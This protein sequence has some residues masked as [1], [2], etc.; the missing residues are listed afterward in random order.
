MH[1]A[2]YFILFGLLLVC[3]TNITIASEKSIIPEWLD[4]VPPK[5]AISPVSQH[6]NSLFYISFSSNKR[7]KIWFS[8]GTA[9]EMI[10]YSNPFVIDKDGIYKIYY[11]GEDDF[12]NKSE[13]DS[14]TYV[15]DSKSPV[16][17]V[18]PPPGIYPQK[19]SIKITADEPCLFSLQKKGMMDTV[20]FS[21]SI[22]V[23]DFF[24]GTITA[25]D[26]AGNIST[27]ANLKYSVDTSSF[28]IKIDPVGG[29]YKHCEL[30]KFTSSRDVSVFYS[31]DPLA[32]PD[33]FTRYDKPFL[34]PHGLSI[35]RFFGKRS[36]S[37][38]EIYKTRFIVDTI[39]PKLQLS[40]VSGNS[41]DTLYLSTREK[42]V[43][44]YTLDKTIPTEK[45]LPYTGKV[46]V[47]HKGLSTIKA[48]AWDDA[49]N[50]SQVVNWEY[51]YDRTPPKINI[52]NVSG[53]YTHPLRIIFNADEPVKIHYTLDGLPA[54]ENSLLYQQSGILITRNDTTILRY[55]GIDEA[56][57]K[58]EEKTVTYYLDTR[59]PEVK[60]SI[61]NNLKDSTFLINLKADEPAVI[62]YTTDGNDP[63]IKPSVY[64]ETIQLRFGQIL[65]YF[66]IDMAG[67]H[68]NIKT[69]DE[70]NR[71][72]VIADPDGGVF[73]SKIKI[74]F[75][76]NIEGNVY[77]RI[78]P[79]TAFQK[80]INYV[81][82]KNNGTYNFEYYIESENGMRSAVRRSVYYIDKTAP[83]VQVNLRKSDNDSIVVF[84]ESSE[85]ASIYYTLDGTNPLLSKNTKSIGNKYIL[86]HDRII[87][88]R[89]N[90][91]KLAF[92]AEDAAGNQ[93]AISVLDVFNPRA[94]P[95]VPSGEDR[96]YDRI[97]SITLNSYDKSTIYFERHGI[98]PTTTSPVYSEPLTLLSSDTITAF[99]IDASG[100]RG[101]LDTF[102]YLIDLPPSPQ[103]KISPDTIYKGSSVVFDPSGS[104]DK[105]SSFDKLLFRWDF[106]GDG[107]F[108]SQYAEYSKVSY[109]YEKSG[110]YWPVLEVVDENKRKAVIAK[111]ILIRE[112][113]SQEMI[114]VIDDG[115]HAFCIDRFEWP[116]IPD[117]K[118]LTNVSWV[119][120]K[121][122]CTDAG[123]R[124]CTKREWKAACNGEAKTIYPYGDRYN[125]SACPTEGKGVWKSGSFKTCNKYAVTDMLGNAWE[126]VERGNEDYRLM[127]GGSFLSGS[128]AHCGLYGEGTVATSSD[129]TGFRCCK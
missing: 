115:G 122:S 44:R 25:K 91:I 80:N 20:P 109:K 89:T 46:T 63:E 22:S 107:L 3:Y 27:T 60:V 59:L 33:Y 64:N 24:E 61:E 118:P 77:W 128:E 41:A 70:L 85:P 81:E 55:I 68:G 98:K 110:L 75:V 72:M 51:K 124:L 101:N 78:L 71:P 8:T 32:P 49:G 52:S 21:D 67:N 50:T 99:V 23:T 102:V 47:A 56:G 105:E 82:I 87:L 114:S 129:E 117:V 31:F 16:L 17:K 9:Y 73:N 120:A 2:I 94:V 45:S 100:H 123:K 5:I 92:F 42:S 4:T 26:R 1:K 57:N 83:F 112:R 54:T 13:I 69:M 93:S 108:D 10:Q 6:H 15:I 127:M 40:V 96:L 43:I 113:C 35:L 125:P 86:T 19:I 62:Y 65:K 38:S 18:T 106:D 76:K 7:C 104:L 97:L 84:F 119:E 79:D 88:R 74:N 11:Y 28:D 48:M 66:A 12:G 53:T 29:I 111:K 34:L 116:N 39:A 30:V 37:E 90:D 103:F 126:W 58:A 121:M 95:N 36:G 14:I